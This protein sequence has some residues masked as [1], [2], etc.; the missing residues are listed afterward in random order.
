MLLSND[1]NILRSPGW[2]QIYIWP[3]SSIYC[4]EYWQNFWSERLSYMQLWPYTFLLQALL[5][6]NSQV[7]PANSQEPWLDPKNLRRPPPAFPLKLPRRE[8]DNV[9][10]IIKLV[11]CLLGMITMMMVIITITII[12]SIIIIMVK[13]TIIMIITITMVKIVFA[14]QVIL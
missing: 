5:W 9:S 7:N 11:R 12:I 14:G 3:L 8:G 10:E 4:T 2:I 13:I 6:N 1:Q